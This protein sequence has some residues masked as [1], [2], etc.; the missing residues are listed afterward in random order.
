MGAMHCGECVD[1]DCVAQGHGQV[2]AVWAKLDISCEGVRQF[3]SMYGLLCLQVHNSQHRVLRKGNNK[4]ILRAHTKI[5]NFFP[6]LKLP[7]YLHAQ[8]DQQPTSCPT[9]T[10]S[11]TNS[12]SHRYCCQKLE[13][14]HPCRMVYSCSRS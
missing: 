13:Y 8:C 9:P 10:H 7:L 14:G 4:L 2:V 12:C 3:D 11:H 5:N 6:D 1:V